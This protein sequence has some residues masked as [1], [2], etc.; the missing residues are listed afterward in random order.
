MDDLKCVV[1]FESGNAAIAGTIFLEEQSMCQLAMRNARCEIN[2]L[3]RRRALRAVLFAQAVTGRAWRF[4]DKVQEML[5]RDC[6]T[7]NSGKFACYCPALGTVWHLQ[8]SLGRFSQMHG[9]EV[10]ARLSLNNLPNPLCEVTVSQC[11]KSLRCY[12]SERSICFLVTYAKQILRLCLT[13]TFSE[14]HSD[15]VSKREM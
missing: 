10:A 4:Q 3:T 6:A 11:C 5:G 8:R 7:T 2:V 1:G 15:T 14:S 12:R 13:M 9:K